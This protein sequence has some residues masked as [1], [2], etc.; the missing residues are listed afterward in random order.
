MTD[1][2]PE[3]L[4][5]STL[6]SLHDVLEED[7][8]EVIA[9]YLQKT[10]ELISLMAN[11]YESKNLTKAAEAAHTI[12]GSSSNLGLQRMVWLGTQLEDVLR[13]DEH[14]FQDYQSLYEQIVDAYDGA[15]KRLL[16]YCKEHQVRL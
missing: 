10:P 9:L 5:E 11:S 8:S 13:Q 2:L 15:Q 14:Q 6:A 12:K 16:Q 1:E 4:L 3:T 7:F